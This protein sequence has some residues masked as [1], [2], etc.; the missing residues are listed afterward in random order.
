MKRFEIVLLLLVVVFTLTLKT[1]AQNNQE[2]VITRNELK[3]EVSSVK[4]TYLLLEPL[5]IKFKIAN[6]TSLPTGRQ[7]QA[8]FK[9]YVTHSDKTV[10]FEQLTFKP[11]DALFIGT[12][13]PGETRELYRKQDFNLAKMFPEPGA[14]NL[15]FAIPFADS[16]GK[17]GEFLTNSISINI[18]EPKGLD[19]E[20]FDFLSKYDGKSFLYGISRNKDAE[21]I[22]RRFVDLYGQSVYGEYVISN[23]ASLYIIKGDLEKAKA[24]LEKIKSSRNPLILKEADRSIMNVTRMTNKSEKA[25][26]KQP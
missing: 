21:G 20:A 8:T 13:N 2:R 12:I 4:D 14:Y 1:S 9:L 6:E 22:Q 24:E 19:K 10:A 7:E 3:W 18:E 5:Q 11:N 25:N 23:L 15:V 16:D 17:M 26:Q